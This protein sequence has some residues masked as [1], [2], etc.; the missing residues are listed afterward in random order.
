MG[1]RIEELVAQNIDTPREMVV[2][3]CGW[4]C[5]GHSPYDVKKWIQDVDL[6]INKLDTK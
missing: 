3:K 2:W 1:D 5:Y 6:Y 4:S